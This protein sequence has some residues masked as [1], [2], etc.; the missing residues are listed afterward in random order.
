MAWRKRSLR[1]KL[2]RTLIS[3]SIQSKLTLSNQ[4]PASTNRLLKNFQLQLKSWVSYNRL[5]YVR[6]EKAAFSLLPGK[7]D[8]GLHVKQ[9]LLM[10]PPTSEQ[11]MIRQC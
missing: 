11:Q 6:L 7:E 1:K 3:L 5:Q 4:E 2:R 8:L 9:G 10:F